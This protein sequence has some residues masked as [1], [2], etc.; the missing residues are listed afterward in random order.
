MAIIDEN[1]ARLVLV[2]TGKNSGDF[3]QLLVTGGVTLLSGSM[4][5]LDFIEGFAPQTGDTFDLLTFNSITGTFSTVN[6]VG[7]QS[8]HQ[9]SSNP[10]AV[11]ISTR[12][13]CT[14]EFQGCLNRRDYELDDS[15][16][17][18]RSGMSFR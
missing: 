14:M 6:V 10:I 15:Q 8:G 3:D 13:H 9:Y 7:L 4:L 16:R 12:P 17:H 18:R 11:D 5:E 1:G 2:F